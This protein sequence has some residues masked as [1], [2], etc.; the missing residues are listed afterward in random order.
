MDRYGVERVFPIM[1]LSIAV[2][3]SEHGEFGSAVDIARTASQLKDYAKGQPGSN[4]FINRRK[5]PR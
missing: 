4:Y 2:V 1:T 5:Q 3:V